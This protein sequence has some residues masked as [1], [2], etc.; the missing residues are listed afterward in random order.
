MKKGILR[1]TISGLL[2]VI[3]F[4]SFLGAITA[5]S[6]DSMLD[7]S[8]L[9]RLIFCGLALFC[10]VAA[11]FIWKVK[12]SY[13]KRKKLI[14]MAVAIVIIVGGGLIDTFCSTPGRGATEHVSIQFPFGVSDVESIEAYHYY[15]DPSEAEKKNI[16]DAETI[17][18]L[19]ESFQS[20]LMQDKD[21]EDRE[22]HNVAIFRFNLRDGTEYVVVYTGYGVKNGE[23]RTSGGSNY[24][25]SADIGGKWRNISAEA[26]PADE[27]ELPKV[28]I[29]LPTKPVVTN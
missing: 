18:Y 21:I 26:I 29:I 5:T 17:A 3:A 19:Y 12:D 16:T 28:T 27:S 13:G 9:A 14:V 6:R 25:T 23:I 4:F 7:F 2:Y 11:T 1:A 20:I 22:I 8:N 24:F 15:S 10:V